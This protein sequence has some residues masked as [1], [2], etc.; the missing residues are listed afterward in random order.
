VPATRRQF[1]GGAAAGAAGLAAFAASS[2]RTHPRDHGP[3]ILVIVIDSLRADHSYGPLA[4]TPA[5]DSILARGLRFTN[6]FPEAMPTVPARNSILTGR[7]GFPFR[8]W[9]DQVGLMSKPGWTGLDGLEVTFPTALQQAG[10]WTGYV[11][12][13]PFLG[14]ARPYDRFRHGFDLFVPHGGQVGGLTGP[15]PKAS[16][17]PWLHPAMVRA[18]LT[19]RIVRYI[20]NADYRLDETQSFAARVFNSGI[21]ALDVAA[22]NRPFLLVVDT[23]EPHEPWTPPRHYLDM[24]GDPDHRGPDPAHVVYGRVKD[25][26]RPDERRDVVERIGALYAAEVTMT[27]RWLGELLG[28][29]RDLDLEDETILVLVADHG[30]QLGDHGWTGKIS[31]ALHPELIHVPLVFVDGRGR[32]EARVSEHYASTH[33]IAPTLLSLA[34][35]HIP[36]RMNGDDLSPLLA[37]RSIPPRPY[38]YGGYS[39]HHFLRSEGWG[40]MADNRSQDMRLYDLENDPDELNDLSRERPDLAQEL[41]EMVVAEAGG[42][43]PYYSD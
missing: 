3:S 16:L 37:G 29:V 28:R 21:Q 20:A 12:D 39:D 42:P 40:F 9:R 11:T 43:L 25:W 14:F 27:D 2:G 23:F 8:A 1:I 10:W 41:H 24:Y 6:V 4:R 5:I 19:E 31:S 26:L 13:N 15:V 33:D 7:R 34:G 18:G 17:D 38:A 32:Q 35:V 30:V 22:R 36:P